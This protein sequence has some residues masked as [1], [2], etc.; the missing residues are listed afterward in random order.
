MVSDLTPS[1]ALLRLLERCRIRRG[2][3]SAESAVMTHTAL[4]GS[5]MPVTTGRFSVQGADEAALFAAIKACLA[6]GVPMALTERPDERGLPL[7]VDLDL[8]WDGPERH[9]CSTRHRLGMASLVAS[10]SVS[11]SAL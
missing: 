10:L 9:T 2:A 7:I 5:E 4:G 8:R 3:A 6:A 11:L 1:Q